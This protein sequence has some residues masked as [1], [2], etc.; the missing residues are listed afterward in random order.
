[1]LG[2]RSIKHWIK[3]R[4]VAAYMLLVFGMEWLLVLALQT[5][6]TP[7]KALFIGAWLPNIAGVLITAV[8][9]GRDVNQWAAAEG[10]VTSRGKA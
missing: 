10:I 9:G 4:P 8:V 1:M 5:V 6:A 7:F 2:F 3:R